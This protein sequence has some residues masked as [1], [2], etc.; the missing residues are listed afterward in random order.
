MADK[1]PD[2]RQGRPIATDAAAAS[3][4]PQRPA[5]LARPEGAPV[6]HG[7]P[8]LAGAEIDG[9]QL[10]K[11]S[12]F[13]AQEMDSGDAFVVAPD[14][15]RA[16]LVWE[17]GESPRLEEV[18]KPEPGRWGVWAVWFTRPMRSPADAQ[19]NLREILPLLRPKWEA[20]IQQG[21]T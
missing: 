11:I 10:G 21:N 8:L 20:A 2:E 17:V 14:G 9:F 16:G 5:F 7:F 13:E 15:S 19:A 4:D 18:L 12:D 6:Y 3:V 1:K